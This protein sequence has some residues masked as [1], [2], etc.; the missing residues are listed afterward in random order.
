M[1]FREQN[2]EGKSRFARAA[3]TGDDHHLVARNL[4]VDVFEVVFA[5]TVDRDHAVVAVCP[6]TWSGLGGAR[7]SSAVILSVSEGSRQLSRDFVRSLAVFAVRDDLQWLKWFGKHT[8]QKCPGVRV[9]DLSD[10]LRSSNGNHFATLV[11]GFR[12]EIDNPIRALDHLEIMLN[13]D[14]GMAAIDQ[15]LKQLQQH[16][17]IVEMQSSRRL[18]ENEEIA[19]CGLVRAGLELIADCGFAIR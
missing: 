5:R 3:Q 7:Q 19:K 4:D 17:D 9:I 18:I 8:A 11:S 13:H 14:N 12:A 15:P 6:K 10:L 1:S 16:R 2:V